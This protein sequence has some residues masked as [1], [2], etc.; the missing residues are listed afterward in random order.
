MEIE[1]VLVEDDE[2][3]APPC[4]CERKEAEYTMMYYFTA[5]GEDWEYE[6]DGYCCEDEAKAAMKEFKKHGC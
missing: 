5:E 1:Y 4:K 3:V 6:S 2:L